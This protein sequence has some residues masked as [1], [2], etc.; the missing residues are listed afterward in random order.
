MGNFLFWCLIIL[1]VITFHSCAN[2]KLNALPHKLQNK[3]WQIIL[4][5]KG[6][7][8]F[9]NMRGDY[10]PVFENPK[11]QKSGLKNYP[12][13]S[14]KGNQ[15][16]Y[17][18]YYNHNYRIIIY[19]VQK[20]LKRSIYTS[21]FSFNNLSWS[22]DGQKLLFLNDYEDELES[23]DLCII[24]IASKRKKIIVDDFVNAIFA[25]TPS[26]SP[27]S[28]KILFSSLNNQVVEVNI[29]DNKLTELFDGIC[30]SY[31]LN[32]K[33]IIY[34]KGKNEFIKKNGGIK[35]NILGYDY[36]I[37]EINNG[38]HSFLFNGAGK[39][40]AGSKFRGAITWS[41]NSEYAMFSRIFDLPF[42][43]KIYLIDIQS[44]KK[45]LFTKGF[46]H[47]PGAISWT[48]RCPFKCKR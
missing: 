22:P 24:D 41:P 42:R 40:S 7:L 34:R 16:A 32:G 8:Y 26:W 46:P 21:E 30:P 2:N 20:K 19:D 39:W 37:Y 12:T 4:K 28:K 17:Q 27:D 10:V 5:A 33:Y 14:P 23:M 29:N 31:S 44:K 25:S 9:L 47:T 36:Y 1:L 35:Y 45:F 11:E 15:I 13:F 38:I 43:E 3:P 18:D 48:A 6:G